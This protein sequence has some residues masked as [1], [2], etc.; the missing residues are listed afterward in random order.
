MNSFLI[1]ELEFRQ[2]CHSHPEEYIVFDK[3]WNEVGHMRLKHG[4][5]VCYYNNIRHPSRYL[6]NR[7][8]VSVKGDGS[9]YDDNERIHHLRKLAG[10][11]KRPLWLERIINSRLLEKI[12]CFLKRCNLYH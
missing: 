5:L 6:K 3:Y 12:H 10:H 7:Y 11:I 8:T 2:S 4:Q 1:S 9:F